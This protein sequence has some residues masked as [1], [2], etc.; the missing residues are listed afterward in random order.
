MKPRISTC[1]T[2]V[3]FFAALSV[4]VQTAAQN[5]NNEHRPTHHHYQLI[6]MGT[7]GGPSSYFTIVGTRPVNTHGTAT[8]AADTTIPDP[9][10]PNCFFP[11]CLVAHT[12]AYENGHITDLGSLPGVNNSGPND[13]NAKGVIVGIS[14]NGAIDPI[15]GFP[16]TV[17]VV[18]KNGQI[19]T[20]PN[21]GGNFSYANAINNRDQIAGFALNTTL[22]SFG[23]AELCFNPPFGQQQLAVIWQNEIPQTL[24]TLG[25]PDSCALWIN[26]KGQAAGH[27][28]TNAV[29]NPV[30]GFPT[31]DPFIWD[32]SRMLDLG[33][34]GGTLGLANKLNNRGQVVGQSNLAGDLTAHPFLWDRGSLIDLGTLGGSFGLASSV[35]DSG[36]IVGG[37][38]NQN[39]QAF[40]AFLWKNGVM[41]N[42]GTLAG[43]DCSLA[44]SVNSGG[45][46]VG[47]SFPC[48]GGPSRAFLWQNGSIFDLNTY[49]PVGSDLTLSEAT[50]VNDRGEIAVQGVASSGDQHAVLLIPCGGCLDAEGKAASAEISGSRRWLASSQ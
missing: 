13:I 15:T 44:N 8:G 28:L 30:T 45:Q 36:I 31:V 12:F 49:V 27:S 19:I 33:T 38:T 50:F 22:D 32:H 23:F 21:F 24:G 29:I 42:L 48:A 10:A 41:T 37:A 14:E 35:S 7:F 47:F 46:V 2:A 43:D 40:F 6:D 34:L 9:Y 5:N 4:P 11:E 39:D 16:E 18:W 25:G 20:L 1:I 17:A 3:A 26:E